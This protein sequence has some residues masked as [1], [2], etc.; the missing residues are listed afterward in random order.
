MLPVGGCL[1]AV[2]VSDVMH[3]LTPTTNVRRLT[4]ERPLQTETDG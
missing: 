3:T 4:E 1:V 2:A